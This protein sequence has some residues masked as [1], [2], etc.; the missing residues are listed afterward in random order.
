VLRGFCV[1]DV[2]AVEIDDDD[3]ENP[4]QEKDA[5]SARTTS[6][7]KFKV[8]PAILIS[9]APAERTSQAGQQKTRGREAEKSGL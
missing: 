6:V 4:W 3:D 1:D 5:K 8:T 9:I 2:A 7:T